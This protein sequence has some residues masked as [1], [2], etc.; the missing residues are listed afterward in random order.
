MPSPSR[1]NAARRATT[2]IEGAR[3]M[4]DE[5]VC[6]GQYFEYHGHTSAPS[7]PTGYRGYRPEFGVCCVSQGRN[8]HLG[9][10]SRILL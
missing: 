7:E 6:S 1:S 10:D 5:N 2:Y 8:L 9:C 4:S 3:T